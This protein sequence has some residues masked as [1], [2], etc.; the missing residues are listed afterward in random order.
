MPLV[1]FR[2]LSSKR[3]RLENVKPRFG[4]LV[5]LRGKAGFL[6][7]RFAEGFRGPTV[8]R[9]DLREQETRHHS[10]SEEPSMAADLKIASRPDAA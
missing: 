2:F 4:I 8:A 7:Q 1:R 5:G 6:A 9:S 3:L 10:Q